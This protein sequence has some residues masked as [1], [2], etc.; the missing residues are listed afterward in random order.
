MLNS[1][2]GLTENPTETTDITQFGYGDKAEDKI[3]ND[4]LMLMGQ[5]NRVGTKANALP[6]SAKAELNS[7]AVRF[8]QWFLDAATPQGLNALIKS[9]YSGYSPEAKS[10]LESLARMSAEERH[11]LFGAALTEGEERSGAEFL[12]FVN[13]LSLDQIMSRAKDTFGSNREKLITQDN[14]RGGTRRQ[15]SIERNN[16]T[17]FDEQDTSQSGSNTGMKNLEDMTDEEL[18]AEL[19]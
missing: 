19:G 11:A 4:S 14:N 15:E 3:A 17:A 12:A 6:D 10:F 7:G 1:L 2:Q 18:A 5:A 16:W 9:E 8:G 13:G